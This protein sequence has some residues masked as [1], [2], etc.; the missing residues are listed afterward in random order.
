MFICYLSP[1]NSVWGRDVS[2]YFVNI[3]SLLYVCSFADLIVLCGDF[4]ARIGKNLDFISEIDQVSK[5]ICTDNVKNSHDSSLIEFLNE[6]KLCVLNGRINPED[7]TFTFISS[8]GKSVVDYFILPHDCL[9]YCLD[10]KVKTMSSII[11]EYNLCSNLSVNCKAPDHFIFCTTLN[12][13]CIPSEVKINDHS[14]N[15]DNSELNKRCNKRY[16]LINIPENLM[17]SE[18]WSNGL[19]KVIESIEN[20]KESQEII[21]DLYSVSCETLFS[22]MDKYLDIHSKKHVN[23]LKSQNHIGIKS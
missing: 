7:D 4:N 17:N 21:D 5:R 9:Q 23:C 2:N 1:E 13:L 14:Q 10:V 8:R 19:L 11:N 16:N 22:E 12:L 6:R 18:I 3:L 15:T 20:S